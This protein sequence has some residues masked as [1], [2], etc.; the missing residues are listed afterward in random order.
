MAPCGR[1]ARLGRDGIAATDGGLGGGPQ[2]NTTALWL[3]IGY[4]AAC[5]VGLAA[6]LLVVRSTRRPSEATDVERLER[7]ERAWLWFVAVGL[8][9]LLAA[10][11]LDTP[12]RASAQPNRLRVH[13]TAKQFQWTFTPAGPYPADRQIEFE[14]TA[15]DVNHGFGV[16]GPDGAFVLQAQVLP[17]ADVI[18]R[19]TFHTK[20]RYTVRCLEFCGLAH[21]EIVSNFTIGRKT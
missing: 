11:I 10:T 19:H 14:L 1:L 15:T 8:F 20:G 3:G 12:W 5:V 4:A 7:S 6:L 18:V 13:V 21:H 17:D 2:V 9:A 16:Y